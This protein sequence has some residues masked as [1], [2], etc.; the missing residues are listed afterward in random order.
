[1][2]VATTKVH[3]MLY[4]KIGIKWNGTV[5]DGRTTVELCDQISELKIQM[6]SLFAM[7]IHRAKCE[8]I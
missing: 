5:C 1:M 7:Q 6:R 8:E 2:Y 3:C 4:L